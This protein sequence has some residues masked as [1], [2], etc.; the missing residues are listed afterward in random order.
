MLFNA[1]KSYYLLSAQRNDLP[2]SCC[3]QIHVLSLTPLL[4]LTSLNPVSSLSAQVL[5]RRDESPSSPPPPIPVR[6]D[7]DRPL[8]TS[9]SSP[10]FLGRVVLELVLVLGCRASSLRPW[11]AKSKSRFHF[12]CVGFCVFRRGGAPGISSVP[13]LR[14]AIGSLCVGALDTSRRGSRGVT[15]TRSREQL[16]P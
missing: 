3:C 5:P 15:L 13:L 9:V 7:W 6:P 11:A 8:V 16:V 12:H 4:S 10:A 2:E 1:N 14:G